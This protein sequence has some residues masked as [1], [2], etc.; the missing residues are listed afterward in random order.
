MFLFRS[1][2]TCA[3]LTCGH[4]RFRGWTPGGLLR[5]LAWDLRNRRTLSRIAVIGDAAWH[6]WITIAGRPLFRAPMKFFHSADEAIGWLEAR[7]A[8]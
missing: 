4:L 8:R 7:H 3:A 1:Y 6:R 2:W 5:D